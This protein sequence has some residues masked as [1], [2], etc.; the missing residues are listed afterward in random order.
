MELCPT[1][2]A[3]APTALPDQ[4]LER[5]NPS[6]Q[7]RVLVRTSASRARALCT[8]EWLERE[9]ALYSKSKPRPDRPA[10]PPARPGE[11]SERVN[12]EGH[13]G[14]FG[15]KPQGVWELGETDVQRQG[16]VGQRALG[17]MGGVGVGSRGR[18][19]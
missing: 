12:G 2:H 9:H 18:G 11:R 6:A 15:P 17:V 19:Q 1:K 4:P 3:H 10:H 13:T 7:A 14:K 16:R 8:A 5:T